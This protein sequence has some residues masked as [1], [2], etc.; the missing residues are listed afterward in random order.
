MA[1]VDDDDPAHEPI[2]GLITGMEFSTSSAKVVIPRSAFEELWW[3]NLDGVTLEAQEG[4]AGAFR[5]RFDGGDGG[6]SYRATFGIEGNALKEY[7]PKRAR[8]P[9]PW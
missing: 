3:P 4:G 8:A 9:R 2:H 5:L 1:W 7:W 6:G